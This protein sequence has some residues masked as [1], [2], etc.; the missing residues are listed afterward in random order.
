MASRWREEEGK[1][2]KTHPS[3]AMAPVRPPVGVAPAEGAGEEH[4][5]GMVS[6]AT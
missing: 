6:A 3:L 1:E 5:Q 4:G 2:K